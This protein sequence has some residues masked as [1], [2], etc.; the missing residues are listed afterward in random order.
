M[1]K[2]LLFKFI[3][4]YEKLVIIMKKKS[5]R[6]TFLLKRASDGTLFLNLRLREQIKFGLYG[7]F[8]DTCPV[9][10]VSYQM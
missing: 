5:H 4:N 3:Y 10:Y 6:Y 7:R 8:Y 1:H 9:S 2:V